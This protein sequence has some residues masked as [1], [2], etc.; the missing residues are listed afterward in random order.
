MGSRDLWGFLAFSHGWTW[1]CWGVVVASG[2]YELLL[3][4]VVFLV[5]VWWWGGKTLSASV[6]D[7]T[8]AA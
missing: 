4:A 5:V 2:A 8:N 1:L 6:R 7:S 3:T